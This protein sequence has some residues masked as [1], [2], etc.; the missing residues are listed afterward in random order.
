MLPRPA[1]AMPQVFWDWVQWRDRRRKKDVPMPK[2]VVDYF[3]K[4]G[5]S[6]AP[7]TWKARYLVHLGIKAPK[8]PVVVPLPDTHVPSHPLMPQFLY[9]LVVAESP[10]VTL[11]RGV[12][13]RYTF[14]LTADPAYRHNY[15]GPVIDAIK[16]EGHNTGAWCNPAQIAISELRT[17]ARDFGINPTMLMGQFETEHEFDCSWEGGL[18]AGMGNISALRPDQKRKIRDF[19]FIA[20]V[21]D[22]WNVMPWM[23]LNFEGLPVACTLKGIYP[24]QVDSPTYGRYLSPDSYRSAGRWYEGDGAYHANGPASAGHPDDIR[25]LR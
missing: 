19:E 18:I 1:R 8:P 3:H 20:V 2:T 23:N 12:P 21:E 7:A 16:R 14:W 24:G 9:P 6:K 13:A 5:L 25:Q 15:T 4:H 11:N 17:F 22:Y 10:E